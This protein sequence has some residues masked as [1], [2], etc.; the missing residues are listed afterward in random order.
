LEV[1]GKTPR[2][3]SSWWVMRLSSD[4][5]N[6]GWRRHKQ[7]SFNQGHLLSKEAFQI[8]IEGGNEQT[9]KVIVFFLPLALRVVGYLLSAVFLLTSPQ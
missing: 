6:G 4:K 2:T 1:V 7:S 9:A 8:E 3:P 5:Y